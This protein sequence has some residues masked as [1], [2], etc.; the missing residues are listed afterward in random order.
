MAEQP[1]LKACDHCGSAAAGTSHHNGVWWASCS[2]CYMSA[3]GNT[4]A[5]CVATWNRRVACA[6]C[7][8]RRTDVEY[9]VELGA[10]ERDRRKVAKAQCERL[11]ALLADIVGVLEQYIEPSRCSSLSRAAE[12]LAAHDATPSKNEPA[13]EATDADAPR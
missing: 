11:R 2:N 5:E 9:A 8:Q 3:L 12:A 10:R 1:E 4:R 13:R 7:E 6:E